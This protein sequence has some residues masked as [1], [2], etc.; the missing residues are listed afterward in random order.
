M[1]IGTG[2]KVS[3]YK[4]G[5]RPRKGFFQDAGTG[6]GTRSYL[7]VDESGQQ[8][9]TVAGRYQFRRDGAG[10]ECREIVGSGTERKRPYLAYLPRSIYDHMLA[11]SQ[12]EGELE[13]SLIQWAD[14]RREDKRGLAEH[15]KTS[16]F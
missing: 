5:T 14:R 9:R 16:K 4:T 8:S 10:W 3:T 2:S 12:T 15:V 7:P 6:T 11:A 1:P 13:A